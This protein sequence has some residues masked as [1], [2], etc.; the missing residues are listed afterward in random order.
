M[1][2]FNLSQLEST[3]TPEPEAWAP[4]HAK[5]VSTA[6][7]PTETP[8]ECLLKGWAVILQL[9]KVCVMVVPDHK[10]ELL[11]DQEAWMHEWISIKVSTLYPI[12]T[13]VCWHAFVLMHHFQTNLEACAMCATELG[14]ESLDMSAE[15][16]EFVKRGR[17]EYKVLEVIVKGWKAKAVEVVSEAPPKKRVTCTSKAKATDASGTGAS[18]KVCL[19]D[20]L[21]AL[22]LRGGVHLV[23]Y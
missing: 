8:T 18:I 22:L 14:I 17:K 9:L 7:A 21:L 20:F 3:P 16:V 11:E 1:A 5:G 13:C 10:P 19:P 23:R 15:C 2:P 4:A 12:C 6:E